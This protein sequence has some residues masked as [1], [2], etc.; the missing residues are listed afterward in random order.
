MKKMLIAL[1]LGASLAVVA[2]GENPAAPEFTEGPVSDFVYYPEIFY[3]EET[4]SCAGSMSV[5]LS[6]PHGEY[7]AVHNV[8][9]TGTTNGGTHGN[10]ESEFNRVDSAGVEWKAHLNYNCDTGSFSAYW[11]SQ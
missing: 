8:N 4:G 9:L 3:G 5:S 2:C 7:I 1:A 6:G 10:Y 11:Q